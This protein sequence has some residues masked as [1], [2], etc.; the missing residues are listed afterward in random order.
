MVSHANDRYLQRALDFP[1]VAIKNITDAEQSVDARQHKNI[2][3]VLARNGQRLFV[4]IVRGQQTQTCI[5]TNR[6][7][8]SP[9]QLR[10]DKVV[11]AC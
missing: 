9:K 4:S 2:A 6:Q 1:D 8:L 3:F 5:V 11:Y 10:V 7:G